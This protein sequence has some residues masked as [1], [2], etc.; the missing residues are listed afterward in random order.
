[1]SKSL[2]PD[3]L[4]SPILDEL[5]VSFSECP[6][7][8]RQDFLNNLDH[9][10]AAQL[11]LRELIEALLQS[12]DCNKALTPA[13]LCVGHPELEPFVAA[14]IRMDGALGNHM[15]KPPLSNDRYKFSTFL[16][17]G[18]MG[19]VWSAD[20]LLLGRRVAV[21]VLANEGSGPL[22]GEFYEEAQLLAS[23]Q[24]PGIVAAYDYGSLPKPDS[25]PYIVMKLVEGHS[26]GDE[27]RQSPSTLGSLHPNMLALFITISDTIGY[28]HSTKIVHRDIN[29]SNI[30]IGAVGEAQVMD[31]GIS[32]TLFPRTRCNS[33]NSHAPNQIETPASTDNSADMSIDNAK[34]TR[35]TLQYMAPEQVTG[36]CVLP[37]SDVFALGAM[38]FEFIA[39]RTLFEAGPLALAARTAESDN[40]VLKKNMKLLRD[41][42][43]DTSLCNIVCTCI[44]Y[45]FNRRYLD[46]SKLAIALRDYRSEL[47]ERGEVARKRKWQQA[48]AFC[49]IIGVIGILWLRSLHIAETN[50]ISLEITAEKDRADSQM[51]FAQYGRVR[52]RSLTRPDNWI[53]DNLRDIKESSKLIRSDQDRRLLRI[54][55]IRCLCANDVQH[56][57]SLSKNLDVYCIAHHPTEPILAVGDNLAKYGFVTVRLFDT[58]KWKIIKHLTFPINLEYAIK[59]GSTDG[60]RSLAFTPNGD[61]L[62][63]GTRS[64]QVYMWKNASWAVANVW[65]ASSDWVTGLAVD[66][67]T[68][69]I[70]GSSKRGEKSNDKHGEVRK[71]DVGRGDQTYARI[72]LLK[73]CVP[74]LSVRRLAFEF[75]PEVLRSASPGH[76]QLFDFNISG[77]TLIPDGIFIS[78]LSAQVVGLDLKPV[79]IDKEWLRGAVAAVKD[80]GNDELLV[81][82][83]NNLSTIDL[84]KAKVVRD[85]HGPRS[86]QAHDSS[87]VCV[88]SDAV[89]RFCV[90][91]DSTTAKV[92]D[93]V[94]NIPL[95]SLSIAGSGGRSA[96]FTTD[97]RKFVLAG[98]KLLEVYEIVQKSVLTS[99]P[100]TSTPLVDACV[101]GDGNMVCQYS[102]D[103]TGTSVRAV[104]HI[105]DLQSNAVEEVTADSD[106][107]NEV[108]LVS[109][110]Q[111]FYLVDRNKKHVV[112]IWKKDGHYTLTNIQTAPSPAMMAKASTGENIIYVADDMSG[113]FG[114]KKPSGLFE[115]DPSTDV[116]R[117]LWSN[118]FSKMTLGKGRIQALA[119][120]SD[121]IATASHDGNIRVHDPKDG[122]VLI[123]KRLDS[124]V[125]QLSFLPQVQLLL[126]GD[127]SGRIHVIKSAN[128]EGVKELVGHTAPITGLALLSDGLFA[129]AC[130]RGEIRLWRF[131]IES[132]TFEHYATIGPFSGA[133]RRLSSS[134]DGDTLLIL[135]DGESAARILKV[136]E[137]RHALTALDLD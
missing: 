119:V 14:G 110:R 74:F 49:S 123:S 36:T 99:Y 125:S 129:S 20:D 94:S 27:F 126:S 52:E 59:R 89:G 111:S 135:V 46:G 109:D 75:L 19:E 117:L 116:S 26:L 95:K 34:A 50:R 118:A 98:E 65:R 113:A 64:G 85:L 44:N 38:L 41:V 71:W 10:T 35:G 8:E 61:R 4:F 47:I 81:G 11:T 62:L 106:F 114:D 115:Y 79:A 13:E 84:K 130:R 87:V 102:R 136:S 51:F 2:D 58:N 17:A 92:W 80:L 68:G 128:G 108:I 133:I 12:W 103:M 96:A 134:R 137:L 107:S 7:N 15:P 100:I 83:G 29:P 77:L 24:H 90:S 56:V 33:S 25:R 69:A 28:A 132:Q 54:E 60:C 42:C 31:W 53:D 66:P 67:R 30:M 21:K 6:A 23:L 3:S 70:Y 16:G 76:S 48:L 91:T 43:K 93:M 63:V 57:K 122:S 78:G 97:G 22:W 45:D 121:E 1:M 9:D 88:Q 131:N 104:I 101:T 127:D 120:S 112:R 105:K 86:D 5:F 82:H 18:S 73:Q 32:T 55:A 39:Q 40:V 37:A 72:M 124:Q